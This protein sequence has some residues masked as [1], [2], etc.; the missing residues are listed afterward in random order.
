MAA[1]NPYPLTG[2]VYDTDGTTALVNA[3]V[4]LIFVKKNDGT[5]VNEYKEWVTAS[6][7]S[8]SCNLADSDFDTD[9][10]TGSK[11][12]LVVYTGNKSTERRHTVVAAG[13]HDFGSMYAHYTKAIL[14][15]MKLMAGVI[16]NTTAGGLRVDLYD[17]T[18]DDKIASME[19][20]AGDSQPFNFSFLGLYFAGGVCVIRESDASGSLE[21]SLVVK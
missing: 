17:R 15:D 14:H 12:Q 2:I 13:G 5:L 1:R 6:D 4:R 18:N 7:G 21:V 11:V 8:F 3:T 10:D 19:I 16:A 20:L 9:Y